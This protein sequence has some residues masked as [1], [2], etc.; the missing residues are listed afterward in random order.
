MFLLF[1]RFSPRYLQRRRV[2]APQ[3]TVIGLRASCTSF[4]DFKCAK[5]DFEFFLRLGFGFPGLGDD[6]FGFGYKKDKTK[7]PTEGLAK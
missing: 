5:V 1:R 4:G 6:Y 7:R 3:R 2:P